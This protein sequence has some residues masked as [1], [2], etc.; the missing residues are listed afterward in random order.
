MLSLDE[1]V[2][3]KIRALRESRSVKP[4]KIAAYL[5]ISL[6]RYAALELGRRPVSAR[7][8]FDLS[9]YFEMPITYFFAGHR[10]NE[11]AADSNDMRRARSD[12]TDDSASK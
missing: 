5:S 3:H 7:H 11:H 1:Y 4:E 10:S 2:G 8:L 12:Q 6:D 9:T